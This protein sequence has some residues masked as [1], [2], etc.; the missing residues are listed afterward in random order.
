MFTWCL[1]ASLWILQ[2]A[3]RAPALPVVEGDFV[4]KDFQFTSGWSL[5]ESQSITGRWGSR[6]RTNAV[7]SATLC[8]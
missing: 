1:I 6:G 8:W 7:S 5:P 2:P 4:L 3:Q